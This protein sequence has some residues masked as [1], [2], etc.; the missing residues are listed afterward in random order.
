[1]VPWEGRQRGWLCLQGN[2]CWSHHLSVLVSSSKNSLVKHDTPSGPFQCLTNNVSEIIM[3]QIHRGIHDPAK[4]DS[5]PIFRALQVTA[6]YIETQM[7]SQASRGSSS[8]WVGWSVQHG[9]E[10]LEIRILS[11]GKDLLFLLLQSQPLQRPEPREKRPSDMSMCRETPE[12]PT[13]AWLSLGQR[14]NK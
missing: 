6:H 2:V 11:H 7:T 12:V 10:F 8:V 13:K 1:M 9:R 14:R 4:L 3:R 5:K